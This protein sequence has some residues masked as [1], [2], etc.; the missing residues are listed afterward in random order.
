M[1]ESKLLAVIGVKENCD[2]A[3]DLRE[4]L[5]PIIKHHNNVS[6]I[7]NQFSP[8]YVLICSTNK[9]KYLIE[10]CLRQSK[11]ILYNS[12]QVYFECMYIIRFN[13]VSR[14]LKINN[15]NFDNQLLLQ[16]ID[17]KAI[18]C[19]CTVNN[20][21]HETPL[22]YVPSKALIYT[23]DLTIPTVNHLSL[24]TF[25]HFISWS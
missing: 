11:L 9:Y 4:K 16:Y 25:F 21:Q 10:H 19:K 15:S 3:S 6:I 13:I 5:F 14:T 17:R 18:Y 12:S 20:N 23:K 8:D 24:I 2:N 7:Y 1:N 22:V